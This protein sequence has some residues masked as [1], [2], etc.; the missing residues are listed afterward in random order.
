MKCYT[1]NKWLLNC[2]SFMISVNHALNVN[3]NDFT[4]PFQA[5]CSH[6]A[7]TSPQAM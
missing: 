2:I 7:L 5:E 3:K 1:F 6:P 4:G